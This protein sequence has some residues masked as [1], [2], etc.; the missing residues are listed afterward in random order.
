MVLRIHKRTIFAGAMIASLSIPWGEGASDGNPGVY[1]LVW[2]RDMV[3]GAQALVA[4]GD[5]QGA[6]DA[7]KHLCAT[8]AADGSWPQNFWLDGKAQWPG[9]QLDETAMP[10]H[11]AYRLNDAAQLE[12]YPAA[13][14][15]A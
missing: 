7:V 6:L 15:M 12:V 3:E 13:Y 4:L 8:Q 9:S 1:H 14:I 5:W 2:S 11:L 10:I